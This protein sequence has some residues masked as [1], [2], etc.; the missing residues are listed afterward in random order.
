MQTQKFLDI[1]FKIFLVSGSRKKIPDKK[2]AAN[3]KKG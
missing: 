2:C 3:Q 1:I